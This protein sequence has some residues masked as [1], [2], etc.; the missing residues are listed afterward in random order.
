MSILGTSTNIVLSR[1]RRELVSR[2]GRVH[3]R[4]PRP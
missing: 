2:T 4:T 3:G 1:I